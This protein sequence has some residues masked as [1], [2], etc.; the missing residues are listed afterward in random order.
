MFG[1]QLIV[2]PVVK[3]RYNPPGDY[4]EPARFQ[5][6]SV[7]AVSDHDTLS[8]TAGEM[9][10]GRRCSDQNV[11]AKSSLAQS[12]LSFAAVDQLVRRK[13]DKTL[14]LQQLTF[15]E[16]VQSD[17]QVALSKR[18]VQKAVDDYFGNLPWRK[19]PLPDTQD[20]P[21]LL[22]TTLARSAH[23]ARLHRKAAANNL[24]ELEAA[25]RHAGA[26]INC[27]SDKSGIT[28][29][30]WAAINRHWSMAAALLEAGACVYAKGRHGDHFLAQV[31]AAK[32]AQEISEEQYR[33]LI[34]TVLLKQAEAELVNHQ[35]VETVFAYVWKN[36]IAQADI[37]LFKYLVAS[38][39]HINDQLKEHQVVERMMAVS[40]G[41]FSDQPDIVS[42]LMGL[43]DNTGSQLVDMNYTLDNGDTFLILA[44]KCYKRQT[45]KVLLEDPVVVKNINRVNDRRITSYSAYS[46]A[47]RDMSLTL[48]RMLEEKGAA[49]IK[50]ANYSLGKSGAKACDVCDSR[51][52]KRSTGHVTYYRSVSK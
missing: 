42:Y 41:G 38:I 10:K 20:R 40:I 47:D 30:H 31:F 50:S 25:M 32:L 44:V 46:Y 27:K 43:Q 2:T 15:G 35:G 8:D 1:T 5:G 45:V 36:I 51:A 6:F 23:G 28:P 26:D 17:S 12:V 39:P 4:P 49:R 37:P 9:K 14:I 18:L 29:L 33:L 3:D 13:S 22:L 7:V 16:G 34:Y 48:M 19:T 21:T 24:K 52:V 11:P